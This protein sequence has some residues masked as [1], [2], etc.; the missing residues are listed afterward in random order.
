MK[1]KFKRL[2]PDG[3]YGDS[4]CG[5]SDKSQALKEQFLRDARALLKHTGQIVA[6]AGFGEARFNVNPAGIACSGDVFAE[7]WRA[8]DPVNTLY[9]TIGASA[10]SFGGRRD[11]LN[12]MARNE[13]RAEQPGRGKTGKPAYHTTFRGLNQWIDPGMHS[14]Q[15]AAELLKIAGR[16]ETEVGIL[17][18]CTYRSRNAGCIEIPSMAIRSRDEALKLKASLGAVMAASQEDARRAVEEKD[19]PA[20][21]I[22]VRQMLLFE[23]AAQIEEVGGEAC[24]A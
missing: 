6:R 15:L 2:A 13:R 20:E 12:I 19:L 21:G 11:G 22:P 3:S 5:Y 17:P 18:G 1:D 14:G 9:C 16:P 8:D 4:I 10:V 7:F 23:E 24:T